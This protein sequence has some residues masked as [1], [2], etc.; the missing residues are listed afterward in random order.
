MYFVGDLRLNEILIMEVVRLRNFLLC[1]EDSWSVVVWS[2]F[3]G[4]DARDEMLYWRVQQELGK[5]CACCVLHWLG[6]RAW[7]HLKQPVKSR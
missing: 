6:G 3:Y 4:D 1:S 7:Y 5:R 2:A